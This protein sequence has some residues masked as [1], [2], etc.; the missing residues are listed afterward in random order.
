VIPDGRTRLYA[1]LGRPIAHTLSPAL[2][3]A[4]FRAEGRNAAYVACDVGED[5]LVDAL[6]G[7]RALG[8]AG[9]NLTAPLKERA[10]DAGLALTD[11]ARAAGA[12]NTVR[13]GTEALGHNTDGEGLARFLERHGVPLAGARVVFWARAGRCGASRRCSR[14]RGVES[15]AAGIRGPRPAIPGVEFTHEPYATR[16]ALERATLVVQATP[17]GGS[18]ADPLPAPAEW[19]PQ[20]ATAVDLRYHPAATPWLLALRARGVRAANGLGML[21][22]QALLAQEFWHHTMPPRTP[23]EEAVEWGDPFQA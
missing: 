16:A 5:E 6:R 8:A 18:D 7:L 14:A 17:L 21:I 13:F 22:E 2:H 9:V 1:V 19:V 15:I 12:V 4:A 3:N 11:E 23:L 10:L 20:A